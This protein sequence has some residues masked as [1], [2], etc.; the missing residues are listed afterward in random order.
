MAK[1]ASPR[2]ATRNLCRCSAKGGASR[3]RRRDHRSCLIATAPV[4][5]LR[6]IGSSH[7][8]PPQL[9]TGTER[10]RPSGASVGRPLRRCRVSRIEDVTAL[11]G[12]MAQHVDQRLAML[13][14]EGRHGLRPSAARR[15]DLR[16]ATASG[17]AGRTTRSPHLPRPGLGRKTCARSR[18]SQSARENAV[19]VTGRPAEGVPAVGAWNVG[20]S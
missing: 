18:P 1:R 3:Q 6:S 17:A 12:G 15:E 13:G 8:A 14:D 7:A 9:C 11:L 4:L 16:D 5:K 19:C 10:I 2:R 20:R